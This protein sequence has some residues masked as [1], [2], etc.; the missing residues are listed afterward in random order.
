MKKH[1]K[2]TTNLPKKSRRDVEDQLVSKWKRN[3]KAAF[4]QLYR[5]FRGW[6][7]LIALKILHNLSDAEDMVQEVFLKVH[8]YTDRFQEGTSFRAWITRITLN[9]TITLIK[10]RRY[11]SRAEEYDDRVHQKA[12]LVAYSNGVDPLKTLLNKEIR[13]VIENI[14]DEMP[15]E[16]RRVVIL[17]DYE[18]GSYKEVASQTETPEGTVMSRLFR[19]RQELRETIPHELLE[20]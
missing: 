15:P 20:E 19:A 5:H 6:V 11:K 3:E 8:R 9:T 10:S 17:R 16:R 18:G 1:Q 12:Q 7:M 4:D 2:P 14:L 13:E